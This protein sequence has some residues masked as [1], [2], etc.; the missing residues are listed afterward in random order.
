MSHFSFHF[1]SDTIT[2]YVIT[3]LFSLMTPLRHTSHTR[4][5]CAARYATAAAIL[6][7]RVRRIAAL[8]RRRDF[9]TALQRR[10]HFLLPG[11]RRQCFTTARRRR[12][13]FR[14]FPPT[15]LRHRRRAEARYITPFS[16]SRHCICEMLSISIG[17]QLVAGC[18]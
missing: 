7:R 5:H 6:R 3:R 16:A 9:L 13:A 10:R 2:D 17:F 15:Q 14:R 18:H 4:P 8:C 1:R 12:P 11:F